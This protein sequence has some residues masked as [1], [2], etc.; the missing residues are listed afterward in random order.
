M[1]DLNTLPG[2]LRLRAL[3]QGDPRVLTAVIDG[4]PVIDHPAFDGADV[5][6]VRG[7]WLDDRE[8]SDGSTGHATHI[9]S[10]IFGQPGSEVP[11]LAPRARGLFIASGVD[12][13]S[14]ES[15]IGIARAI[16]YAL[17]QGAQIIHCAFCHPSQTGSTQSWLTDAV[18]K[19]EDAGAII[20]APAGN[21]YGENWC[22]PA[23]MPTVL[24]VGALADDGAPMH[25]TNFGTRYDGHS[26][27]GPGEN[28][29]GAKPD[30][31]IVNQK[32]TSVAAP[33]LTGL[34]TAIT[35]ALVQA[36][37]APNPQLVRDV[38]IATAR[39]CTGSGAERCIGGEVAVDRALQVLFDGVSIASFA[40]DNS[41]IL[42][43]QPAP[44]APA[45]IPEPPNPDSQYQL[46]PHS[47]ATHHT[48]EP[49]LPREVY[50][51]EERIGVGV[52]PSVEP[53]LMYPARTFAIG[54]ISYDFGDEITRDSFN[55]AMGGSYG[56]GT[57][58]TNDDQAMVDYLDANPAEARKLIWVLSINGEARFAITPVGPYAADVY[59]ML[60][61]LL[62]GQATG[63][64]SVV[65][66]PG[67]AEPGMAT[68]LDGTV[69]R[70][71]HRNGLR[72]IYGWH[73]EN[74]A[75]QCLAAVHRDALTGLE[76]GIAAAAKAESGVAGAD[77]EVF[78][79]DEVGTDV[80][81]R[82]QTAPSP[83]VRL[84]VQD[85]L[86]EIYFRAPQDPS[87]S[88]ERALNLAATNGYQI[89]MAFLDALN[90]GFDYLS[91]GTEYSPFSRV[92]GNCWEVVLRFKDP[93]HLTR[94]A[95]EYR[96]T[97]D[98]ADTLPVAV[99][100]VR[101]WAAVR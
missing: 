62:Q 68:L 43:L 84:A 55:E 80:W 92:G 61:A 22:S 60:A 12:D 77:D 91:Y 36:G 70:K 18:R 29:L 41:R 58:I 34:I 65:S 30:G 39:P 95:R 46:P 19:A 88:V 59:D 87:I 48:G 63:A 85:F 27:M 37:Q 76:Q 4:S 17:S 45:V 11:G 81:T 16:E 40:A 33:V 10:V 94:G 89:A 72:G 66:M 51:R 32:G 101:R 15:E 78:G 35:S 99:G 100:R 74:L 26:I 54:T 3:T 97:I 57:G 28:V 49:P 1:P 8:N 24:A 71:L 5:T 44:D 69:I 42:A 64:I 13:D 6:S 20:V 52:S 90:A 50:Q 96:F 14:A 67:S 98:V 47:S 86:E 21:D 38:L 25:F 2:V 75:E 82:L 56:V 73:P 83:E 53:S 9:T 31:S 23:A 7:Y 79:I 93:A